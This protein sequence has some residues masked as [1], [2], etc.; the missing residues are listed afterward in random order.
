MNAI[1]AIKLKINS[2]ESVWV[3]IRWPQALFLSTNDHHGA[4]Q[5]A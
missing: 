4:A 3:G 1:T 2:E 5:G